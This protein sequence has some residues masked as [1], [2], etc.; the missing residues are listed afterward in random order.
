MNENAVFEKFI[1]E[2]KLKHS[3]KRDWILETFLSLQRH[4]TVE[5]V[6]A[7]AKKKHPSIGFATVYRTL[8]LLSQSGLCREIRFEDGT[9]RYEQDNGHNHHDHII[10]TQ[11][12]QCLEVVDQE[13]EKLQERLMDKNGFR[14][15]SHRL[16]LYGLC[17]TCREKEL[18]IPHLESTVAS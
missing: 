11:C 6:W 5:D 10:C 1:A 18:S 16:N 12:G 4:V 2:K 8:K 14:L 13:I 7:A 15:I 3:R 17:K 9:T